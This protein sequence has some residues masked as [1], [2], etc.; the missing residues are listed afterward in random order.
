[1]KSALN[2]QRGAKL[3]Y[4]IVAI[5]IAAIAGGVGYWS[6]T[7]TANPGTAATAASSPAGTVD[8]GKGLTDAS[9]RRVLYWHDPMVPGQKFDKPGKSPF[10]DM[11]LVP[12]Y[13]DAAGDDGKITISPRLTQSFG[14]RTVEAKDGSLA[15]GFT[16]VGAIAVDERSIVAVQSRVQGYI[17]QLHVRATYDAVRGGQPLADLYVPEWLSAQ[18]EWLALKASAQPGAAALADAAR[19]RLHLL[20][21]PDA[22]IA[23]IDREGKPSARVTLTAP[24]SGIVWEIGARDG[25]AV[26]PGTTI[27]RLAGLG[28][29]WVIA[30]VPEAQAGLLKVGGPVEVHAAAFPDRVFKGTVGTLLPEVNA[31]TRTVRARIVVGN[32]GAA[33]KPGMFANVAFSG[34]AAAKSVLVPS[35]AVIQTGSRSVVIVASGEGKFAPV[36]V[37]VGRES[38]D[39]TEIHKGIDAG[40]RVVVSSQFL[41]DSEASLKGVLAR[42]NSGETVAAE[43]SGKASAPSAAGAV[44]HKGVGTVRAV[45]GSEVL[46]QH[47][48]IASAGMGAM[49]MAYKAPATGVPKTVKAGTRVDFEFIVTPGGDFELS[50]IAPAAGA[51][52]GPTK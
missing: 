50:A 22:E 8:A 6:G 30:E 9:G 10:M 38:G 19:Q 46:L 13:A 37:E 51:Q 31:Q 26:M 3:V 48:A 43:T 14:V 7:R 5:A 39:L 34:P 36:D 21:M 25:M 40:Q 44:R 11:D 27:Y 20:G 45:S 24:E 52:A 17:E 16:A 49:T 35:E 42:M 15:G 33:L 12:V 23:R 4:V 32:P 18:E 47:E 1:M 41:I 28:S 29:V 2:L